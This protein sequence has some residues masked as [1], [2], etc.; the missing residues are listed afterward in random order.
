MREQTSTFRA[1]AA[2]GELLLF[3]GDYDFDLFEIEYLLKGNDE[4][5]YTEDGTGIVLSPCT[6]TMRVYDHPVY[7]D[8][9]AFCWD[10]LWLINVSEGWKMHFGD[11]SQSPIPFSGLEEPL[12]Q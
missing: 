6:F 3:I 10:G 4:T 11:E 1:F 12:A 5:R 2:S 8:D 9:L 7:Q